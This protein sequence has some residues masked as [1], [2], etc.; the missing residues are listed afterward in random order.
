MV[1]TNL[2]KCSTNVTSSSKTKP[3]WEGGCAVVCHGFQILYSGSSDDTATFVFGASADE[4]AMLVG[5]ELCRDLDCRDH[6]PAAGPHVHPP[7]NRFDPP[8]KY[9]GGDPERAG[10]QYRD[11]VSACGTVVI[12]WHLYHPG[13]GPPAVY[14][15]LAKGV[16]PAGRR[17]GT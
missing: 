16:V 6:T 11:Y 4:C 12:R 9:P 15:R 17:G 10:L 14:F 5:F 3:L 13:D 2:Y 7:E 1:L 8:Q